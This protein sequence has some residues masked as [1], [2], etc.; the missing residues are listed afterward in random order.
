[1]AGRWRSS[2]ARAT[3]AWHGGLLIGAAYPDYRATGF[4][5]FWRQLAGVDA[6]GTPDLARV[7]AEMGDFVH[8]VKGWHPAGKHNGRRWYIKLRRCT[9]PT[10]D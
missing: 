7:E 1:M 9:W 5:D 2:S 3:R 6:T 10:R 4:V 8:V